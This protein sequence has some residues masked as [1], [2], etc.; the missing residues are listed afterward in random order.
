MKKLK[1]IFLDKKNATKVA[2]EF[3]NV[4]GS[5]ISVA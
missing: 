1:Q 4:F 5:K 3:F 2:E